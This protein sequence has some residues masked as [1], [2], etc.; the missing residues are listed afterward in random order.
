MADVLLTYDYYPGGSIMPGRNYASNEYRY[1]FNKGSEKDDEITGVT[2]SHI[3]TYFREYDL[4]LLRTWSIDPVFQP[5]Q[6]PYTSMDNNPIW[7]NDPM[8]DKAWVGEV[9]DEGNTNYV[10]EK[11]DTKE[12]LASQ[13]GLSPDLVNMITGNQIIKEGSIISGKNVKAATKTEKFEGSEVLK[14]DLNS[15]RATD[16]RKFNQLIFAADHSRSKNQE[17][18]KPLNYFKGKDALVKWNGATSLSG[19]N[20]IADVRGK[21]I[22][23]KHFTANIY[24]NAP[25]R[26][27]PNNIS[28]DGERVWVNS[29]GDMPMLLIRTSSDNSEFIYERLNRGFSL[30]T[31]TTIN[32]DINIEKD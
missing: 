6:S 13:Y 24:W 31:N 10:A 9:D 25:I 19:K 21:K 8:G 2:G 20:V 5:W 12:T 28:P 4:R 29:I 23:V 27:T 32:T 18:Y 14:L 1:G 26:N 30:P 17:G 15:D 11:G 7:Y 22:P 3:T 16:Q